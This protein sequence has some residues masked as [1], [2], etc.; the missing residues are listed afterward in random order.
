MSV[1]EFDIE[2]LARGMHNLS[3]DIDV[4]DYVEEKYNCG[5]DAFYRIIEAVTPLIE[6]GQSP[7]TNKKYKGFGKDGLFFLKVEV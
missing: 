1:S 4:V 7:L 2:E 6:C 3:D 5:W